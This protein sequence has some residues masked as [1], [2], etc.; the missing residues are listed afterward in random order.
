MSADRWKAL[1]RLFVEAVQLS[2]DAREALL[3]RECGRDEPLRR[4]VLA[5]LGAADRSGE[6]LERPAF[7]RLAR[8]IAADGW[9]L[10][11]GEHLGAYVVREMLGAGAVGEVWRATDERL[12]RDVAIKVLL[13]HLSSEPERVRG[14]AEEARTAGSL[15]HPNIVSVHDIGE[16]GGAPYIVSEYADGETLR[17]RL[18]R[19]PMSIEMTT[20]VT[21]QI[22]RGLTA[23][24]AQGIVH[25]DLKPDNVYLRADGGV[26]ILDFGL[27][28]LKTASS[29]SIQPDAPAGAASL[30]GTAGY[31]APE[32]VIGREADAR[33]DLFALGVTMYEMLAGERPFKANSTVDTLNF[34]LALTPADI[35]EVRNE[36]PSSLARVVSRLLEKT[37]EARFQSAEAVLE[38]L[39]GG[40]AEGKIPTPRFSLRAALPAA[41][42]LTAFAIVAAFMM[43]NGR[44]N[45]PIALGSSGRPAVAVL[46][47]VNLTGADDTAWLSTAI[48]T[49]LLTGLA[50]TPGLEIVS[51]Q[52]LHQALV[53]VGHADLVALDRS[54]AAAVARRAGAGAVV[55]GNIYKAGDDI[56]IDAQV[57]DLATGR[58]LAADSVRGK[59]VFGLADSLATR[60]R[61]GIGFGESGDLRR[62]T[63][64]SSTSIP[65]YHLYAKGLDASVNLRWG[66]AIP[67]MEQAIALD[68]TFAEAHLQLASAYA[69]LGRMSARDQALRNASVHAAKLSER[70]RLLL[71]VRREMPSGG[72][73]SRQA[74]LLDELLSRF[75][76]VEEAYPIASFLYD[77]VS[78]ALPNLEKLLTITRTGATVLSGS[79][80]TRNAYGYALLIAGRFAEAAREFEEYA[81]LVPREPNPFDS[82]GD[83]YVL[84]GAP[85]KAVDA[86]S[87][88]LAIDPG[89]TAGNGLAYALGMSGR[90]DEA[91]AAEVRLPHLR[92]IVLS[93]VGRYGEADRMIRTGAERADADG[94][95]V[96]AGGLHLVSAVLAFE[97]KD[98]ARV[99]RDADAARPPFSRAP[100]SFARLGSFIADTLTGLAQLRI[101]RIDRAQALAAS[102]AGPYPSSSPVQRLWHGFLLGE[103]ALARG[104]TAA[105]ATAFSAAE[106]PQ[107][108]ISVTV[109]GSVLTNNLILRDGL[110]R[111]AYARGDIAGAIQIYRRLLA[112]GPELKW[113][114]LY[115]P[116]Y[117]LQLARLLDLAGDTQG[118]RIEYGRFLDLWK[119]A[120]SALPELAEAR[121][122]LERK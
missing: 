65:A 14:F 77:P 40:V 79:G 47:F 89:F 17:M 91:L 7:E 92:A 87:R 83:A 108:A 85:A 116:R 76:D 119:N 99:L 107:R 25:R 109:P 34:T 4:E 62:I 112:N 114:S 51:A 88:A 18:K 63:D 57:E 96:V 42:L 93:R 86:Y 80:Q 118:A 102:L 26:K 5:L 100:A 24:H 37:P 36:V 28:K 9:S 56:R 12:G 43:W 61:T 60:I 106:L 6:F 49:M 48:P 110:A 11:P 104:D 20:G 50:E 30:A 58:V 13:P 122:A 64:V 69:G 38:A 54:E 121:R 95:M 113:T 23:A 103:L 117:V 66:E 120:D 41:V 97:R 44:P 2:A 111:A 31:T 21:L 27:A 84:V 101:G 8:A 55:V 39:E 70:N 98:F 75:P 82:L 29:M 32:Q 3:T 1:D 59:D 81:R 15:N 33:S 52:R 45:D 16:H 53:Q 73:P 90:Y 46:N 94:N 105:A 72:N 10:R 115:E 67:L 35:R 68:P 19:G 71:A 74:Q 78:G 22:I